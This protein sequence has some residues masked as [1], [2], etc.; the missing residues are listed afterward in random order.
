MGVLENATITQNAR[1]RKGSISSD[2]EIS[3][4]KHKKENIFDLGATDDLTSLSP[5][6]EDT[7]LNVI[8]ARFQVKTLYS[9]AGVPLIAVNPF[10]DVA[11]LYDEAILHKYRTITPTEVK[12]HPPHIFAVGRK[13]F[14]D[15][16][17]D[18]DTRDQS[19]VISGESG[20]GKTW[21]TRRLMRFLTETAETRTEENH[22]V[23]KIEKRILDS[24]PI[25]EAFGNAQT[26]KNKNSSRFGKFIQLQ[27][28]RS[29][30]IVGARINTYLLEKTRVV[31]QAQGERKFHIF[32]QIAHQEGQIGKLRDDESSFGALEKTKQALEHVGIGNHLQSQIFKVLAGILELCQ[33]QF[34]EEN[35][36]IRENCSTFGVDSKALSTCKLLQVEDELFKKCLCSRR[37]T[38]GSTREQ[39]MKPC[40]AAECAERRD[41]MAKL[42]YS[43]LFDWIVDF[44]NASIRAPSDSK[45]SFIG[46]LDIYGF[47]NF[48]SNSLEQLCINYANEKL[49]Q[50]F[51]YH[52]MMT[53][54][55][56]YQKEGIQWYFQ[57]FVDN[58]PCL[59]LIEGGISVFSLMNEECRLKR[60]LD[61]KS[62]MIRLETSLAQNSHF[63]CPRFK[64]E[65]H[66]FAIHHFAGA[67]SYQAEGLVK[68]NKDF[69]PPEVV[70]LLQTSRSVLIQELFQDFNNE[71]KKE[72]DKTA[73]NAK[74]GNNRRHRQ[75]TVTVVHKFKVSL[76]SLMS[77]LRSTNVHYIRC[78]KP[79]SSCQP[80]IFDRKQ[81]LS[82]LNACGVLET[83]RISAAGYPI[84]LSHQEFLKRYSLALKHLDA[85]TLNQMPPP[86]A[87]SP[88]KD[89]GS[90]RCTPVERLKRRSRRRHRS[91]YDHSRQI[92]RSIVE[93]V[94]LDSD[95][96]KE[97]VQRRNCKSVKVG[98]TKVFLQEAAMEKLEQVRNKCLLK[99]VLKIQSCWR[100]HKRKVAKKRMAAAVVIQSVWRGWI[101]KRNYQKRL[102]AAQVIQHY[103]RCWLTKRREQRRLVEFSGDISAEN[104]GNQSTPGALETHRCSLADENKGNKAP[105]HF[106]SFAKD[107]WFD[108]LATKTGNFTPHPLHSSVLARKQMTFSFVRGHNSFSPLAVLMANCNA[109]KI[110]LKRS[111]AN[112]QNFTIQTA[113]R[114]SA[115]LSRRE[116][117][118]TPI[119]F[120]C[121]GT[122]LPHAH[123]RPHQATTNN[124]GL[125]GISEMVD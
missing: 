113:N 11:E 111:S 8:E 37:I 25:L 54:Q 58:R 108:H 62:F 101:A 48:N 102:Q 20:A 90:F 30:K 99:S 110:P 7:V 19:I 6:N 125:A 63:S 91:S 105:S 41:C 55:E 59:H 70:E 86:Q 31:H 17:R 2:V 104:I 69:I 116:I 44:M 56:E 100:R 97:N 57:D 40:P 49:Q 80:G 26:A 10:Q 75:A 73:G 64:Q 84:R 103:F 22:T 39:F 115:I 47:E 4:S 118:K 92:C 109:A 85:G 33:V 14:C 82:Q 67:V 119:V 71:D 23:N 28:D 46:L 29:Q 16:E 45:Y 9:W 77:I 18:L 122:P 114:S 53:Q 35:A 87:R 32:E 83:I 79:N 121:R 13:A 43:R 124:T 72:I 66:Q 81:V 36:V 60:E 38:T 3:L 95:E 94:K 1:K 78:V 107:S 76:D 52:F 123:T 88:K 93:V 68:K 98:R 51:V 120:H 50:H 21:T 34:L 117:E 112:K 74:A 15:L 106:V 61:T 12:E 5:L 24:N 65:T 89:D 42:I 96:S 27:Y